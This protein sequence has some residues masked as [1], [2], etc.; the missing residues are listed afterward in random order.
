[1][2]ARPATNDSLPEVTRLA[3]RA[4]TLTFAAAFAS[5]L[6]LVTLGRSVAGG[7][8]GVRIAGAAALAAAIAAIAAAWRARDRHQRALEEAAASS[9]DRA[10]PSASGARRAPPLSAGPS[11][12]A[13]SR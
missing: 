8:L 7:G 9:T 10:A 3:N 13:R 4:G 2:P 1:M 5:I 12:P 6:A 11:R